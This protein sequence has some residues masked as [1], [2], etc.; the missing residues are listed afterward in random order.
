MPYLHQYS[1]VQYSA[2][3]WE[4][5]LLVIRAQKSRL[6]LKID[7][8]LYSHSFGEMSSLLSFPPPF[9]LPSAREQH[10]R[11]YQ[12]DCLGPVILTAPSH[13]TPVLNNVTGIKH[14]KRHQEMSLC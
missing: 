9:F 3:C 5:R 10:V 11:M 6:E 8:T 14:C 4:I 1:A 7:K 2:S 12:L 13:A